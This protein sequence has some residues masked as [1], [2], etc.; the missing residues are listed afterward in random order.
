M[1]GRALGWS[2]RKE[3]EVCGVITQQV[4]LFCV[5][6]LCWLCGGTAALPR[7]IGVKAARA[8]AQ[9]QQQQLPRA[10]KY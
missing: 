1:T 6:V 4:D 9:L 2:V 3:F 10:V 7:V 5:M 8:L